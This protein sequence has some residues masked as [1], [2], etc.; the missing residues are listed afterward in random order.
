MLRRE[1]GYERGKK[2]REH[3]KNNLEELH[4]CESSREF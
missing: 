2:A 4:R 1:K 3:M